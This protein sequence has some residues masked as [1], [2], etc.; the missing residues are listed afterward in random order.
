MIVKNDIPISEVAEITGFTP[1]IIRVYRQRYNLGEKQ[2]SRWYFSLE[3]IRRIMNRKM[4]KML[5]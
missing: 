2:G 4:K 3:D 1:E 5:S